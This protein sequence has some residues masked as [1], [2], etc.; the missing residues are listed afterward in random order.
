MSR[1]RIPYLDIDNA[2]IYIY[3]KQGYRLQTPLYC[4]PLLY[5]SVMTTCWHADPD[6]RPTFKQL[7]QDIRH[8]LHQLE[9]EEQQRPS[10]SSDDD[11][12]DTTIIQRYPIDRKIKHLSTTSLTSR[13]MINEPHITTCHQRSVVDRQD[14][15]NDIYVETINEN[16]EIF[17]TIRLLPAYT[18]TNIAEDV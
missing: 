17:S 1:G 9:V 10:S 2:D 4:P 3:I 11:D 8:I 15:N 5:K 18:E 7:A 16:T 6:Q 12:D 13:S 14:D